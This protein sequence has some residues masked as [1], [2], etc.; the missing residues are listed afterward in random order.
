MDDNIFCVNLLSLALYIN[1]RHIYFT[2][3]NYKNIELMEN[4]NKSFIHKDSTEAKLDVESGSLRQEDETNPFYT[5]SLT[6][7]EMESLVAICDTLIPSID[8]S[9]VGHVDDDG[10]A[11]Y[12][13]ASASQ[14]GTPDRVSIIYVHKHA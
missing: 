1:T 14:T 8:G 5:N 6:A 2:S 13:S 3:H 7:R 12:Y 9:K 10:V 11:R 4:K